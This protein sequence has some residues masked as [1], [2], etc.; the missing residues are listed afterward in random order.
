MDWV[1][2]IVV[3][4]FL[5]ELNNIASSLRYIGEALD[6]IDRSMEDEK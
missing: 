4:A 1:A 5:F 6:R 3:V 2:A